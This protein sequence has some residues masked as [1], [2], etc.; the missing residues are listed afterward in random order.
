MWPSQ[1]PPGRGWLGS[2]S[3][4][5]VQ[6]ARLKVRPWFLLSAGDPGVEEAQGHRE[7]PLITSLAGWGWGG[8]VLHEEAESW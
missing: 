2:C 6:T 1:Q 3:L 5:S 7:I 4:L 8:R